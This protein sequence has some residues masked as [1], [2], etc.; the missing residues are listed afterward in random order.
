M[1]LEL[2]LTQDFRNAGDVQNLGWV[3]HAF[4]WD[5]VE[6]VE[7]IRQLQ[8]DGDGI[9]MILSQYAFF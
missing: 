4:W 6:G 5:V 1:V 3:I 7:S 2:A 9:C 8:P